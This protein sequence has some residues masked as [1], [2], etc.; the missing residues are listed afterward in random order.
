MDIIDL[1]RMQVSTDVSEI[2][3]GRVKI[4]QEVLIRPRSAPDTL[5]HGRVESISS[6][7]RP[8]DVWRRGAI[9]GKKMF[10]M[11][12]A[13]NESRPDLLRPGMTVDYEVVEQRL[14]DVVTVPIQAIQ[15]TTR[16]PSVFVRRGEQFEVRPVKTGLRNDNRVVI[17]QGLKGNEV[18]ALRRPPLERILPPAARPGEGDGKA[19]N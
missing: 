2:D 4:G 3:I 10:R 11:L 5:L 6:L 18:I 13:V 12:I 1:S 7:A 16:G 14:E 15:T 19:K 9:P 17:T 8:G